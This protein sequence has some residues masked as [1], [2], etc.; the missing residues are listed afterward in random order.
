MGG[1]WRG[2][3]WVLVMVVIGQAVCCGGF[4]WG[5]TEVLQLCPSTCRCPTKLLPASR[6]GID[7]RDANIT[8]LPDQME[9][10]AQYTRIDFSRNHISSLSVSTF[11]DSSSLVSLDLSDNELET[12]DALVFQPLKVLATLLLKN[13]KLKTIDT[14]AFFG[15]HNLT[16]LDLSYNKIEDL[17]AEVLWP[18]VNLEELR[19]AFNPLVTLSPSLLAQNTALT[20]LDL[21]A[22]KLSSLPNDFFHPNL[23]S[24]QEV[25]LAVN[26]M[27]VVPAKALFLLRDSLVTL[28]LSGNPIQSLGAY[29]FFNLTNLRTL[30]LERFLLLE[31]IEA[32]AFGDLDS[33]ETVVLRYMPRIKY[34]HPKAFHEQ[35]IDPQ[36]GH[37]VDKAIIVEDFTFSFSILATLPEDLLPWQHLRQVRL[38]Y[39]HWNCDCRM[40]WVKASPLMNLVD[41]RMLC[42]QP[43]RLRG[44]RLKYVKEED[45]RC[46]PQTHSQIKS[47]G[48]LVGLMV[49]GLGVS[50]ATVSLLVYWRHG[51]LCRRPQGAY[52]RIQRGPSTI[53]VAD[54]IEYDNSRSQENDNTGA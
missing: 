47:F 11:S 6:N 28:D 8:S 50:L 30:I 13:N 51:W 41:N 5:A 32:Y 1:E 46:D 21:A 23:T 3:G 52:S 25:S 53:T 20:K 39:N 45:L 19:L 12:I 4:L 17:P 43:L 33:L 31:T 40:K 37:Q 7:C 34:I 16:R 18:L 49:A 24:L 54:E 29:S 15:L 26:N 14:N 35:V 48:F 10:P 9:V 44:H 38:E 2:G 42:S 22:L 36:T 27:T